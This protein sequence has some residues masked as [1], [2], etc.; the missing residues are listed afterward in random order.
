MK[1]VPSDKAIDCFA[2]GLS[3]FIWELG[4]EL[5]LRRAQGVLQAL[6]HEDL[7]EALMGTE[8]LEDGEA[9]LS[10]TQ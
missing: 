6:A 2:H 3:H 5:G 7:S 1:S 10:S 8:S 9:L 4:P